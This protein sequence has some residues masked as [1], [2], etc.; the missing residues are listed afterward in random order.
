[1][2]IKKLILSETGL[3]RHSVRF[4]NPFAPLRFFS[5]DFEINI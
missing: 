3:K 4:Y 1:M 5:I 2:L